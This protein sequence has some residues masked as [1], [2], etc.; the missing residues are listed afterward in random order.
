MLNKIIE[1]LH[2]KW[3]HRWLSPKAEA[4]DSDIQGTGVFAKDKIIKG[5]SVGV[6]GGVIV[7][8]D[9]IGEYRDIMTQV[10]IQIDDDFFIVPTTREELETQGVFNHSCNPNIG[11][12]NS[13]TYVA[14][15]DIEPGEELVFDYAFC[16]TCYDGFNCH[17][18]SKTC[19]HKVTQDD[20]KNKEIQEKYGKYFS[21]YLRDKFR[22]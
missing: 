3:P 16:E 19:R 10:G 12:S 5:E 8:K 22:D 20:W 4:H 6:L 13:I 11:F 21:P 1:D 7:P 9:Q 18:G 17:C 14:M 2:K 15:R